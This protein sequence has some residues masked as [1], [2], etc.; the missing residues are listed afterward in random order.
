MH[1]FDL[2]K[3][4]RAIL[5]GMVFCFIFLW[6]NIFPQKKIIG[7]F[8]HNIIN[9]G[10]GAINIIV[11]FGGG[12]F[13]S[14]YLDWIQQNHFGILTFIPGTWSMIAG[15]LMADIL[16]YWWHRMNHGNSFLWQF[17]SLHHEDGQ[18]NSTTAIRFHVME[19]I[20]SFLF[21]IIFYSLFGINSMMLLIFST[22]HFIMIVFHHSNIYISKRIDHIIRIFVTSPLMHRIHHSDKWEETN[23]N[24]T[25]ILSCW[26]WVFRSYV[27]HAKEEI[28][29]GVPKDI[30]CSN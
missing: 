13:F 8:N 20:L 11:S 19:L 4:Y 30:R 10:Y 22:I 18:M 23:S 21:R 25:S 9:L 12:Y 29:F 28:N 24:Y 6:E 2:I 27:P 16:M 26:D 15:L 3:Q 14:K 7:N 5:V 1:I 17:H